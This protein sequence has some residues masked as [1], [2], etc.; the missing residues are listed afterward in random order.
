MDILKSDQI[1]EIALALSKAQGEFP[2]ISKLKTAKVL[3]KAGGSYCYNYADLSD[4]LRAILP[5]LSKHQLALTQPPSNEC[6]TTLLVH[7]SGQYFGS[8]MKIGDVASIQALGGEITYLRRYAACAIVGVHADED[9]DGNDVDGNNAATSSKA[10]KKS[11]VPTPSPLPKAPQNPPGQSY[12]DFAKQPTVNAVKPV[13]AARKHARND[14]L[15]EIAQSFNWSNLQVKAYIKK[16]WFVDQ[17][18]ELTNDQVSELIAVIRT[19][20]PDEV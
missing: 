8:E 18:A 17:A 15:V 4:V 2:T 5:V 7:S 14:E 1:N 9:L 13:I 6:V 19:F 16:T 20:I 12:E 3:L 11:P 10:P